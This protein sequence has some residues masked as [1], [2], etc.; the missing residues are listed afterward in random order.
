MPPNITLT[1]ARWLQV[2]EIPAAIIMLSSKTPRYDG[3]VSPHGANHPSHR[4]ITSG[5]FFV[6]IFRVLIVDVNALYRRQ[7]L[8]ARDLGDKTF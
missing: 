7:G 1:V 4:R 3:M 5:Y 2:A 8:D 6:P